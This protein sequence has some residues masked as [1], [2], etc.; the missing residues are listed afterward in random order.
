MEKRE[1]GGLTCYVKEGAKE[2]PWVVMLHG[3]GADAMDLSPLHQILPQKPEVNWLF[4]EAPLSVP[5]GPNMTGRAWFELAMEN[6]DPAGGAPDLAQLIPEGGPK[7]LDDSQKMLGEALKELGLLAAEDGSCRAV[8]SGFSQGAI[9][10]LEWLLAAKVRP[11]GLMIFSGAPLINGSLGASAEALKGLKFFQS[12][13]TQDPI[14][15]YQGACDLHRDLEASGLT[16]EFLPF[17]GGHTIGPEVI[18]AA[19]RYLQQVL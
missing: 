17:D 18:G 1:L 11:L 3:Y 2:A 12:H 10:S 13:G 9:V 7:G 16:G 6:L 4:P 15:P 19:N 5:L 14:L 8:L